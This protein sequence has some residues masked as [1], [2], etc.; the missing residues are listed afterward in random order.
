MTRPRPPIQ[1]LC[2]A[3][4]LLAC[5]GPAQAQ[6]SS[7]PSA[8]A[9]PRAPSPAVAAEK[10][11]L[12]MDLLFDSGQSAP[13]AEAQTRLAALAEHLK[14]LS[15]EVVVAV[16]HA[17]SSELDAQALSKRRADLAKAGLV[18]GGVAADRIYTEGQ[19]ANRPLADNGSAEGRAR[20]RRVE[21][22]VVGLR[23]RR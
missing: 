22:E 18:S 4:L 19:G 1:L 7:A 14:G 2:A 13:N 16:G 9:S 5:A 11:T 10:V 20:N 21:L 6:S 23:S 17:D 12:T 3:A 15:V 8:P